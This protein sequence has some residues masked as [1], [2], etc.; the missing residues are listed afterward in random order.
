VQAIFEVIVNDAL[1]VR[2]DNT[3]GRV[4]LADSS[5][6]AV[7][8]QWCAQL[9]GTKQVQQGINMGSAFAVTVINQQQVAPQSCCGTF[10][11][12]RQAGH[13]IPFTQLAWRLSVFAPGRLK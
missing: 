11:I 13:W 7:C 8:N 1:S 6:C 3:I 5:L 12:T 2:S 4:L 10:V 9:C